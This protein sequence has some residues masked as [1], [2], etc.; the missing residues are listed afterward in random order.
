VNSDIRKV[1]SGVVRDKAR[2]EGPHRWVVCQPPAWLFRKA[3]EKAGSAGFLVA[4]MCENCDSYRYR[5]V[6]RRTGVWL[7]LRWQ[8]AYSDD[9]KEAR[10]YD[11]NDMR[12]EHMRRQ[13]NKW[14]KPTT[15][16]VVPI[17]RR[18]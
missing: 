2:L 13:G 3:R 4:D 1:N 7:D 10:E 15:D 11:A 17:R 6:H 5:R 16:N 18:A 14:Q 8:I 12:R 9:F